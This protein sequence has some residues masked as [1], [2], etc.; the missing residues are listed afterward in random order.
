M[1]SVLRLDEGGV[2]LHDNREQAPQAAGDRLVQQRQRQ[3]RRKRRRGAA[4]GRGL[5]GP[6]LQQSQGIDA[7]CDGRGL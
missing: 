5:G 4:A 3:R 7:V 1:R 6:A 2:G